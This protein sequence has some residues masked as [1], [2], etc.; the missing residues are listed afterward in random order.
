MGTVLYPTRTGKT[1]KNK[2]AA[3]LSQAV[4][5][6]IAIESAKYVSE[7]KI[8]LCF[9]DATHRVIDFAPFLHQSTN[10]L[11]RQ[12]LD[13]EKFRLFSITNGDLEWNDYDLCFPIADLYNNT[14]MTADL[15]GTA[16]RA[17]RKL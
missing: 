7:Y 10:I 3:G 8:N 9:S 12:Y 5:E 16:L 15:P 17:T 6:F 1:R 13:I 11:I 2:L 4:P 14:L